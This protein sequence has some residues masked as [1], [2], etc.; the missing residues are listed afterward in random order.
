MTEG[1]VIERYAFTQAF[2]LPGFISFLG[3]LS[4]L[5]HF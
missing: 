3:E 4:K 2:T 1:N 5:K